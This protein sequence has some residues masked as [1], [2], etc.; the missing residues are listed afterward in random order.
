MTRILALH[1]RT[2]ELLAADHFHG[3]EILIGTSSYLHPAQAQI[4]VYNTVL[5]DIVGSNLYSIIHYLDMPSL[6]GVDNVLIRNF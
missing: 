5:L 2:D 6:Y 4:H 1:S 3:C